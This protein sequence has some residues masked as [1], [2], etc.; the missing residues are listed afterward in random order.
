VNFRQL[1]YFLAVARTGSFT[2]AAVALKVAQ[3]T[4]TKSIRG[5]E[6]EL[7]VTL[8]D[9]LPRGAA[10]TAA[11]AA[12]RRHAERVGVQMRD[13]AE[14]LRSIGGGAGGLV[15]IGA[16]PAW[17]RRLLPEAVSR[18]ISRHPSIRV[19][20][21]GGFDDVLLKAL[22]AGELDFV[23]A[24][25]PAEENARDLELLPLTSD[26]LAVFCRDGHPLAGRNE[27]L[28]LRELLA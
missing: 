6:Q 22:R 10:L 11:G 12:L 9:R 13:A 18:A 14:E 20:V 23:V 28:A 21:L 17:L 15:S 25:L 5:L 16:G 2:A 1:D 4:L 26:R 19:N 7:G 3:P 27:P 24:E 8:F